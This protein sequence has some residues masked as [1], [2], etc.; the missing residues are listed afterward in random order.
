MTLY[1][2]FNPQEDYATV[3]SRCPNCAVE[4]DH[5]TGGRRIPEP[6]DAS[7][8]AFCGALLEYGQDLQLEPW[9]S[10]RA[11]P[12]ELREA[13]LLLVQVLVMQALFGDEQ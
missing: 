7:V 4:L 2:R 10:D 12:P 5:A 1:A 11:V 8:C 3:P 13:Q 6:G 9:P